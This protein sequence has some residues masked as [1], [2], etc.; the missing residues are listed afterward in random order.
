MGRGQPEHEMAHT[1]K[2]HACYDRVHG[3]QTRISGEPH[4]DPA[5][6]NAQVHDGC[7]NGAYQGCC[8]QLSLCICWN[9]EKRNRIPVDDEYDVPSSP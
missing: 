8:L 5:A 2:R 9:I 3:A 1:C 4:A 6:R 7:E